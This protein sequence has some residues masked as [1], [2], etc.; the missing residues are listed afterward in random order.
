MLGRPNDHRIGQSSARER[1]VADRTFDYVYSI[2]CLHH[3]GDLQRGVDDVWRVLKSGGTAI[4]MLYN[5]YSA[6]QLWRIDRR[7]L[8]GALRGR[9]RP[10]AE[11]IRG[12]YDVNTSLEAAPHTDFTSRKDARRLLRRFSRVQIEAKNFDNATFRGRRLFAREQLLRTPLPRV[13]GLDL[14]IVATK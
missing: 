8:T 11:Q 2:G 13:L 12:L 4:L 10:S 7:R 14:Y 5:R 1:P 6:R 3:T 9:G